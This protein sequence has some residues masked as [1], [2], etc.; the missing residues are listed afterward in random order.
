M[1]RV[2]NRLMAATLLVTA[3]AVGMAGLRTQAQPKAPKFLTVTASAPKTAPVGKPFTILVSLAIEEKYHLQGHDA[4]DPDV[5]TVVTLGQTKGF[6][7]GKVVYPASVV[8]AFTGVKSPVYENKV[9]IKVPVTVDATVKPG[10]YTLPV[11][12]SYQGC[13]EH[14]CY[15]PDKATVQVSVTVSAK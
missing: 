4:K 2:Y 13:N 9:E 10:K 6:K 14:S 1:N 7:P 8:K 15:P 12:V 11:T 3:L 5:P